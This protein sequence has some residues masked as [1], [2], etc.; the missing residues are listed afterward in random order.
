MKPDVVP[1]ESERCTTVID[2]LGRLMPGLSALIAAS[3]HVLIWPWKILAMV[4]PSSLSPLLI[5]DRL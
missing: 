3:F 4:G 1:D 2:V 5:P